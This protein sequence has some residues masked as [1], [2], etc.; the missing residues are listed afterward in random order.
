[1]PMRARTTRSIEPT[2]LQRV[3]DGSPVV[4]EADALMVDA[5]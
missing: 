3:M 2:F 5:C 1:M 4:D